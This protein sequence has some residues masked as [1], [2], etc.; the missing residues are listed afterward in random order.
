MS[1]SG[2][3]KCSGGMMTSSLSAGEQ[4]GA[5]GASTLQTSLISVDISQ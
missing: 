4:Q 1:L 3:A 5:P 2:N